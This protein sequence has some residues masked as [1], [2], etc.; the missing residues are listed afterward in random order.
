MELGLDL[1]VRFLS[2]DVKVYEGSFGVSILVL[3]WV[4]LG[5]SLAF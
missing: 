3:V 5:L 2:L 1:G 4:D